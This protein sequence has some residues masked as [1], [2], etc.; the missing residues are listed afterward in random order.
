MLFL[1]QAKVFLF[2]DLRKAYGLVL[3]AVLWKALE[4]LGIP[5]NVVMLIWSFTESMTFRIRV[6]GNVLD[7][8]DVDNDTDYVLFA[9]CV[10]ER[11]SE[12]VTEVDGMG[13][14]LNCK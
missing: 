10:V 5:E 1:P 12:Q 11:S 2:V 14:L 7:E 4:K 3:H 9:C 8:I 6:N 13:I